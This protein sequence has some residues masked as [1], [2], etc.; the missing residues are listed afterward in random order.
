MALT[1]QGGQFSICTTSQSPTLN[2]AAFEALTY[3]SVPGIVT[4]PSFS[5][6]QNTIQ[7]N[8]LDTDIANV[9]GGFRQG[10]TTNA[11]FSF[12]EESQAGIAAMEDAARSGNLFAVKYELNNSQGTNGTTYFALV[13][14]GG[15]GG[16][17]GGGGEDF[18]QRVYAMTPSSQQPIEKAAA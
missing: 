15:G 17:T 7:E 9:Q 4:A 10:Q 13:F 3:V 18:A 1:H 12:N 2:L 11:A 16:P 14:I 6:E 8:T 5:V